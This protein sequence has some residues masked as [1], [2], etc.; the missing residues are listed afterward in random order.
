MGTVATG[1]KAE[2][3][4]LDWLLHR[5]FLLIDRNYRVG[6]KEIDLIM[7][8]ADRIHIVEVKSLTAPA[9]VEPSAKVN[10]K[11][12]RLLAAAAGYYARKNRLLKEIQFDIV[13]VVFQGDEYS[14]EYLPDAFLPIYFGH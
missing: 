14:L 6:H 10:L 13:T 11:K 3:I 9:P 7:E 2:D 1:R 5:G 12:Q 8:S 4:A